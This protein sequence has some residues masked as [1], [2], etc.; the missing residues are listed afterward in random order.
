[1][2]CEPTRTVL[3][4]KRFEG[5]FNDDRISY[6]MKYFVIFLVLIGFTAFYNAYAELD[7]AISEP[8][9][10]SDIV[11]VATVV[12]VTITPDNKTRYDLKVDEYLKGEK[13]FDLITAVL[14]D[15]KPT[16]FPK[17]PLEYFNKP[18]FEKDNHVFVYLKQDG[19]TF[20]MLPYSF[21][22][23][24]P[25]VVGPPTVIHATGPQE[26]IISQGE[27]IV[28]SGNI[29]KS[30]LYSLEKSG[31]DSSFSLVVLNENE[32][33]VVSK[34]LDINLDGSYSFTFQE[35]DELRIPGKYSWDIE[36]HNGGMGGEFIV[37][38]DQKRWTPLKQIQSD[39]PFNEIQCKDNLI[40]I[41]KYDGSP[42]CVTPKSAQILY[43]RE[44]TPTLKIS[45][46]RE[47]PPVYLGP[48]DIPSASNQF[49][50]NFYSHVSEDKKRNI[51]FS[52]TSIFTAF[53]IAYEGAKDNTA[54]EMQHV[55]GF[56]PDKSKRTVQ[57]AD[58][59][60]QLNKKQQNN[61]ISLANALWINEGFDVLPEYIDTA[62][63]HYKSDIESIN[64]SDKNSIDII[65][66]WI[67]EKTKGK[68]EKIF[69]DLDPSTKLVITNAIYF[70]GIWEEPFDQEKT[71]IGDFHVTSDTVVQVP[72][73][74][75]KTIF[76]NVAINDLVKIVELPYEGEKFSMLILLPEDEGMSSLEDSL[77][78]D[79]LNKWKKELHTTKTKVYMPKFKLETEYDLKQ[80]LQDMGIHD[81]FGNADFTGISDSGLYIEK[82]I[83]KAFVEVNE[84]GTEAAAATGIVMFESGPF[85]FIID[86]PFVFII[87]DNETGSILFMGKVVNPT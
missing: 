12:Q 65:N 75:S 47:A 17:D 84:E 56:E 44:W 46:N 74:E 29:K 31:F 67:N 64:F 15:T 76:P 62:K 2:I 57:F 52:P 79:N 35:K 23:K 11:L 24:K 16:N 27:E 77:S 45:V 42:A 49:A 37:K 82:A 26:Y 59:Q 3:V 53:A 25:T 48:T 7:K 83:H 86:R 73:M 22:I 51:F 9:D 66:E 78:V 58:M 20:Q 43:E 32:E 55:F 36:Y 72:M 61:T 50:L 81:A 21:T 4:N 71:L 18:Y 8:F 13:P 38:T 87:Q 1:M 34:K 69:E 60:E 41:Q 54:S 63:T 33:Q 70:K 68:I 5:L 30:Y 28:I 19:S 39:I 85:E 14:D 10:N 40:L 6:G 80:I